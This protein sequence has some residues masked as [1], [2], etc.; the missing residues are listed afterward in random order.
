MFETIGL[1]IIIA[2]TIQMA[3]FDPLAL[4]ASLVED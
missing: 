4:K 2:N 1:I 3:M